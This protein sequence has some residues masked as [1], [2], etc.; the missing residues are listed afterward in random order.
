MSDLNA[1]LT[2]A[3]AT[4]LRADPATLV[5]FG[6]NPILVF[7]IVPANT[8]EP[9]I[10]LPGGAVEPIEAEGF[11]LSTIVYPVHVWSRPA[12]PSFD[13]ARAIAK[14]ARAVLLGIQAASGGVV[15]AVGKVETQAPLVDPSDNRTV[16]LVVTAE[17]TTA[18]A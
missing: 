6:R 17:F 10:Q 1:E 9:Y 2:Q 15:Y 5:A 4:A 16:H 11:D 13:E 7:D 8:S 18:P 3:V 14:A 12:A